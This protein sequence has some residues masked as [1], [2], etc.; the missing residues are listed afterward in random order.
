MTEQYFRCRCTH[1]EDMHVN[2]VDRCIIAECKCVKFD[3]IPRE[4]R[5][6]IRDEG[7][8]QKKEQQLFSD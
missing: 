8:L 1:L 3:L 6:P 7:P 5:M 2:D 4:M